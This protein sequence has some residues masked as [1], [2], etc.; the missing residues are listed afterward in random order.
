M[1]SC[2]IALPDLKRF[3]LTKPLV[4]F[5]DSLLFSSQSS[6]LRSLDTET[7]SRLVSAD[8]LIFIH[9]GP[10]VKEV[11]TLYFLIVAKVTFL[12]IAWKTYTLTA[13][14][15]VGSRVFLFYY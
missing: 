12:A 2:L 14:M 3:R 9:S 11:P 15:I 1:L 13:K 6:Q 7:N 10:I 4:L 5:T 8:S